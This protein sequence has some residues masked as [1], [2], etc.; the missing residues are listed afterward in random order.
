[1][2]LIKKSDV[3]NHLSPRHRTRIH[4]AAPASQT[5]TMGFSGEQSDV[6]DPNGRKVTGELPAQSGVPASEARRLESEPQVKPFAVPA[7]SKDAKA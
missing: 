1:M 7:I 3:K 4:L 2:S 5:D 6:P